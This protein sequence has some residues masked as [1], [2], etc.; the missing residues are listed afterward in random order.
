MKL[1]EHSYR[2][3]YSELAQRSLDATFTSEFSVEGRFVTQES[4]GRRYWFSTPRRM[5][6]ARTAA[7]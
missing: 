4:N 3:L 6:A 7:M 1:I 5:A 2:V